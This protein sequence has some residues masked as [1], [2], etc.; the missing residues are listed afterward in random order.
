MLLL[1]SIATISFCVGT[2]IEYVVGPFQ[3]LVELFSKQG[4][5]IID[6]GDRVDKA[7]DDLAEK[8]KEVGEDISNLNKENKQ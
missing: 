4:S 5:K 8:I 6:L 3:Y 7:G 1:I 2:V